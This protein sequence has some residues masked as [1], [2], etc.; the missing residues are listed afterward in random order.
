[1]KDAEYPSMVYTVLG[2]TNAWNYTT[3]A[4][5]FVAPTVITGGIGAV[6]PVI[7][8]LNLNSQTT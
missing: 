5:P 2:T 6:N 4:T 1:M 7:A 3:P 8:A